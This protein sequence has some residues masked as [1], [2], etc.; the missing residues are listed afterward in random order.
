MLWTNVG[1]V[2]ESM[3][4]LYESKSWVTRPFYNDGSIAQIASS[5]CLGILVSTEGAF[6]YEYS[7]LHA[8]KVSAF[9]E[10]RGKIQKAG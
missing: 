1:L 2:L 5:S 3:I 7:H 4:E 6:R 9:G 8:F 10:L